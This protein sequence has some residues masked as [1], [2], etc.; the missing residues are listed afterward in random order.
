MFF[1]YSKDIKDNFKLKE[2]SNCYSFRLSKGRQF[3][4]FRSFSKNQIN[5]KIEEGILNTEEYNNQKYQ[6]KIESLLRAPKKKILSNNKELLSRIK[7]QHIID[8][9]YIALN[10]YSDFRRI[11]S[12]RLIDKISFSSTNQSTN[13]YNKYSFHTTNKETLSFFENININNKITLKDNGFSASVKDAE[14]K[15]T[16]IIEILNQN[17]IVYL[18][19]LNK[20]ESYEILRKH[21]SKCDCLDCQLNRFELYKLSN[22]INQNYKLSHELWDWMQHAYMFFNIG[23]YNRAKELLS[24]I[25]DK[26]KEEHQEVIY[27]FAKYNLRTIAWINWEEEYPDLDN[28][29]LNLALNEEKKSILRSMASHSLFNDYAKRIDEIYLKIKE[30]KERRITNDTANLIDEQRALLTEYYNFTEGNWLFINSSVKFND[31]VK[32]AIESCIISYSMHTKYSSH[33]E[34]LDDFWVQMTI[35]YCVPNSLLNYF[36]RNYVQKIPYSSSSN[37][38]ENLL[39]SFFNKENIDF[40]QSEI[41]YNNNKTKNT[42]LRRKI[43]QVFENICILLAYLDFDFDT[44]GLFKQILYFIERIDLRIHYLS[45]LAHPLFRKPHI[46]ETIDLIKLI[47]ILISDEKFIDGY[48]LTNTIRVLE[49]KQFLFDDSKQNIINDIMNIALSKPEYGILEVLPNIL[50]DK[51]KKELFKNIKNSLDNQFNSDLFYEAILSNCLPSPNN[52]IDQY[53]TYH[54]GVPEM[55]KESDSFLGISP[56][57]GINDRARWFLR[58]FTQ[59]V[60]I[61][62]IEKFAENTIFKE[63]E[64]LHPYYSFIFNIK[65]YEPSD[66]FDI[67]WL[68]ENQ[69]EIVLKEIAKNEKVKDVL[70]RELNQKFHKELSRIYFRYFVK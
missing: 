32:K 2:E 1:L 16:K 65:E 33:I 68:L 29:L 37:Y 38:F 28:E 5:Q 39:T 56:Y 42:Y 43:E 57:I 50:P 67:N 20:N 6:Q 48:L 69:S 58:K 34:K 61:L 49:G 31:I 8:K 13:F 30:Y 12:W 63:I 18:T 27:F 51:N 4:E 44:K 25:C 52:Y 17:L 21:P 54:K 59:V 41:N 11:T 53:I 47:E 24:N 46:F 40:I 36:Q 55:A 60:L 66:E 64:K 9:L 3:S 19:D 7:G 23:K 45:S 15:I 35:H 62:G 14:T 10:E 26:A 22:I 70:Q